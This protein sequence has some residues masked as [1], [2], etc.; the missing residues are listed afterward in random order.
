MILKHRSK[1]F[2]WQNFDTI[3][4]LKHRSN[5]SAVIRIYTFCP[6]INIHRIQFFDTI[7]ILKHRSNRKFLF[8]SCNI[9]SKTDVS[10]ARQHVYLSA[11]LRHF[12]QISFC[13]SQFTYFAISNKF[14]TFRLPICL[15]ASHQ[16]KPRHYICNRNSEINR[17]PA[18]AFHHQ[19]A[20]FWQIENSPMHSIIKMQ[21]FDKYTKN[22][23]MHLIVSKSN[24]AFWQI[25]KLVNA[26]DCFNVKCSLLAKI[27]KF[28]SA[29]DCF[30]VKCNSLTKIRKLVSA[31]NRFSVGCSPLTI[32]LNHQ[33]TSESARQTA[34]RS[35]FQI[36]ISINVF[37]QQ[38]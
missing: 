2:C 12:S 17:K 8:L 5:H 23:S 13:K 6:A 34:F 14:L 19:S 16:S 33:T 38:T 27:R 15:P 10:L 36:S 4:I 22:S 1:K 3:L 9:V 7:L 11:C 28:V 29:F 24:A 30:N 32:S 21:L 25:R 31:F 18:S 35:T 37:H 26:F 20:V